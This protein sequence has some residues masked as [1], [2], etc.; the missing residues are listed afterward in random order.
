MS[1]PCIHAEDKKNR[2]YESHEAMFAHGH[3]Q[4]ADLFRFSKQ[5]ETVYLH[6]AA[7]NVGPF[8]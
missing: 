5:S 6:R 3:L 8:G 1:S 7:D 4:R 2:V